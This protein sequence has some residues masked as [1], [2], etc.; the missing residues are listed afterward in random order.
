MFHGKHL[1]RTA[2]LALVAI[3]LLVAAP[4]IVAAAPPAT[5]LSMELCSVR[6]GTIGQTLHFGDIP[7]PSDT[8]QHHATHCPLCASGAGAAPLT[9]SSYVAALAPS[10]KSIRFDAAVV[11]WH[12]VI[13]YLYARSRAPPAFDLT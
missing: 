6:S 2:K 4:L 10:P 1:Q 11:L 8:G 7:L 9:A 12:G 13:D 3:L 5:W